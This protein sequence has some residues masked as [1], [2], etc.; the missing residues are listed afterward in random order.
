MSPV[1]Y[2]WLVKIFSCFSVVSVSAEDM[3]STSSTE[4]NIAET[5]SV[6]KHAFAHMTGD[7]DVISHE[8]LQGKSLE[9][10]RIYEQQKV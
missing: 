3:N 4:N 8:R 5:E 2:G 9:E 7:Q 10:S 6:G 1:Y